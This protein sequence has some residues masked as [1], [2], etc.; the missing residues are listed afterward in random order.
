[1][2]DLEAICP[3]GSARRDRWTVVLRTGRAIWS[4][5]LQ[6][7]FAL[8]NLAASLTGRDWNAWATEAGRQTAVETCVRPAWKASRIRPDVYKSQAAVQERENALKAA[9]AVY[10]QRRLDKDPREIR[11]RQQEEALRE[12]ELR[13][14]LRNAGTSEELKAA[15]VALAAHVDAVKH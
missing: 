1:S 4:D 14:N 10:E 3:D 15:Q 9:V 8:M 5:R 11:R 12:L 13:R 6:Y 7:S 2:M